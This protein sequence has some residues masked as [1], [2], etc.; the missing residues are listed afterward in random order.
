MWLQNANSFADSHASESA[1]S[2]FIM[3]NTPVFYYVQ[4]QSSSIFNGHY[5]EEIT[6]HEGRIQPT[7]RVE[8]S[9]VYVLSSNESLPMLHISLALTFV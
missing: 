1:S 7:I 3:K 6:M 9:G 2:T 8:T 5:L 4:V